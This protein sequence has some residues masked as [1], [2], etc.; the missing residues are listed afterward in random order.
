MAINLCNIG[1]IT[2]QCMGIW[3][4]EKF[5]IIESNA[6]LGRPWTIDPVSISLTRSDPG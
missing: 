3:I 2:G 4:D 5:C 1:E 6:M